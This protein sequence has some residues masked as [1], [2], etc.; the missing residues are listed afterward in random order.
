[1]PAGIRSRL[2]IVPS[3][4]GK[5][6][7]GEQIGTFSEEMAAAGT[8]AGGCAD[9]RWYR[10]YPRMTSLFAWCISLGAS[11][12]VHRANRSHRPIEARECMKH[13]RDKTQSTQDG[14]V[15][16]EAS[17]RT[18]RTRTPP[19]APPTTRCEPCTAVPSRPLCGRI[20]FASAPISIGAREFQTS[21]SPTPS[22]ADPGVITDRIPKWA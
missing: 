7:G 19:A 12:L 20:R 9:G 3:I 14:G 15:G 22:V 6:R 18:P 8:S 2:R 17:A 13:E 1:L 10:S 11:R 16:Y 5:H 4:R 21:V